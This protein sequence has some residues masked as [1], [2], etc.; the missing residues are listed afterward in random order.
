KAK[1]ISDS[2]TAKYSGTQFISFKNFSNYKCIVIARFSELIESELKEKDKPNLI[3]LLGVL[4][5]I[6]LND[7]GMAK[8]KEKSVAMVMVPYYFELNNSVAKTLKKKPIINLSIGLSIKTIGTQNNKLPGF[9]S[10][11][12]GVVSISNLK[13][14]SRSI[15]EQDKLKNIYS[16]LIPYPNKNSIL[17]I[18]LSVVETGNIGFDHKKAEAEITA[19]KEAIGPTVEDTI[20]TILS[21]ED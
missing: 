9:F 8:D 14:G 18:S 10:I 4:K 21:D 12:V 3:G 7:N 17:S 5:I 19:V 20:K 11:G 16:D 2:A 15:M 6:N 1:T 13:L